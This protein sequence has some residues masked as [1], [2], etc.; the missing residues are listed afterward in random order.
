MSFLGEKPFRCSICP[1]AFADKSNLRA[2]IQT[3]S[4]TKP[5][6]CNR[7]GKSFALKSYLYKHEESS[8][9]KNHSKS[10]GKDSCSSSG[11]GEV[12]QRKDQLRKA[13]K[14]TKLKN[15]MIVEEDREQQQDDESAHQ[16]EDNFFRTSVIRKTV[17]EKIV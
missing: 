5:H 3:H 4:N 1:K 10:S 9:L 14:T 13:T 2:H 6:S 12:L 15:K 11:E 17:I 7:C 8:C 16:S